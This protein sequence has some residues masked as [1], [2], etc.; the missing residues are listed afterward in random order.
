M[1]LTNIEMSNY[2]SYLNKVADKTKGKLAYAIA[3]N[4]RKISNESYEFEQIRENLINKYGTPN[5]EGI[6]S[7]KIDSDAY[8]SFVE[9][10][11]EYMNIEH[12]VD[13]YKIDP[14]IIFNSELTAKEIVWLD[15]M[16]EDEN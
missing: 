10:I 3:R 11:T 16:I 14:E 6:S 5:E 4:I 7:I 8:K 12:E 13:I 9:E 2:L 1:K 15:F